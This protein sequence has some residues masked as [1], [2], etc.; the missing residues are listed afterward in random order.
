M[1]NLF[2]NFILKQKK[3][4]LIPNIEF[5]SISYWLTYY[6][7]FLIT[8]FFSIYSSKFVI[9][10]YKYRKEI[11]YPYHENDIKWNNKLSI[12]YRIKASLTGI[13]SGMLGVEVGLIL[14]T[15]LLD[16]GLHPLVST[17]TSNFLIVFLTLSTISH[18]PFL[19][20][21]NINYGFICV[22]FSLLGSY[23]GNYFINRVVRLTRKNSIL[24]FIL[25]FVM[26]ISSVSIHYH[27]IREIGDVRNEKYFGINF[28][29]PC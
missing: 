26:I 25:V 15:L 8:I 27:I 18:S 28:K 2:F 29:T 9:E 11:G 10:E 23:I 24:I 6:I 13:L 7:Y 12:E 22:V 17:S 4:E 21:L 1:T 19:G 3:N 14:V 16:I 20:L 5:C